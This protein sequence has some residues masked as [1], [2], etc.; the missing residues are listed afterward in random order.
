MD[1][2]VI[3]YT[4]YMESTNQSLTSSMKFKIGDYYILI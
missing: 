1:F 4:K 2:R 3:P